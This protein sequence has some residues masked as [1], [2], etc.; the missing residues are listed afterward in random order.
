MIRIMRSL[1]LICVTSFFLQSCIEPFQAE[2]QGF[3]GVLV[4][5]AKLT[6]EFKYQIVRLS[7]ARPFEKDSIVTEQ[8]AFVKISDE[9]GE[10]FDFIEIGLGVYQ[11]VNPFGAEI[12]KS[13]RLQ[14]VTDAGSSFSSDLVKTPQSSEIISVKAERQI[15]GDGDEGVSIL[16]DTESSANADVFLRF[17]YDEDYKIIA[18]Y[19]SPFEF[20]IISDDLCSPEG[21]VVETKVNTKNNRIC[22]GHKESTD[23]LLANSEQITTNDLSK[24]NVRFV[25]RDNFILSH[26]YSILVKQL[27]MSQAAFAY[28]EDLESFS[29][30][31]DV[32]TSVQPGFLEGNLSADDG[33]SKVIGFFE[34]SSVSSERIFFDYADF[35]QN[36]PL[37]EYPSGCNTGSPALIPPGAHCSGTLSDGT[38]GSPLIDGIRAGIYTYF[39]D[40]PIT[41]ERIDAN[42]GRTGGLGPYLTKPAECGDCTKLGS[43]IKPDFWIE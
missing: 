33:V 4:I 7:K 24:F 43:N 23:I 36:D 26:R 37:P 40:F 8:N 39:D 28:Y 6:D 12:G 10:D 31:E 16:V 9:S 19:W 15:K 3:E 22:Y 21:F 41:Q 38:E 35:F 18:P 30:S 5:D 32:F 11:S 29:D 42:D 14:V 17:E 20:D 34:V 1:I 27:S 2:T 13:Y 25:S